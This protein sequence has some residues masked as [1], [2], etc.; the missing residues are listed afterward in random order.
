MWRWQTVAIGVV[1]VG[2]TA[3]VLAQDTAQPQKR[4]A[5][6]TTAQVAVVPAAPAVAS[7]A[8]AAV[9]APLQPPVTTP[10]PS[11]PPIGDRLA[12]SQASTT[13]PPAETG[14]AL[15]SPHRGARANPQEGPP[16]RV[17]GDPSPP[18]FARSRSQYQPRY[19]GRDWPL[20]QSRRFVGP[21]DAYGGRW[22]YVRPARRP[23]ARF[24]GRRAARYAD[25][26]DRRHAP[27]R[28][29][30]RPDQQ[31]WRDQR[32]YGRPSHRYD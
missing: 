15:D 12:P 17:T 32:A 13:A 16:P 19:S 8:R 9:A 6:A 3:Q 10:A 29:W 22:I 30:Q 31:D 23:D 25:I 24:G 27:R 14:I 1:A 20:D 4:S 18:P 7:P 5:V 21:R 26:D 11:P 28:G 2:V